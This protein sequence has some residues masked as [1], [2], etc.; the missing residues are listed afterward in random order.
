MVTVSEELLALRKEARRVS[1]QQMEQGSSLRSQA[2]AAVA[3]ER[4]AQI[5][6]LQSQLDYTQAHDELIQA[7]GATP[8]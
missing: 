8:P 2:Q 1:V 5:L 6:L 3:E 7:T 4:E